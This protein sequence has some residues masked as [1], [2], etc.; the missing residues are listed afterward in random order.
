M[1]L[2]WFATFLFVGVCPKTGMNVNIVK[3]ITDNGFSVWTIRRRDGKYICFSNGIHWL[4]NP[5]CIWTQQDTA[6]NIGISAFKTKTIWIKE[7]F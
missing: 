6:R 2:N 7:G 4:E 5:R 3:A 1:N